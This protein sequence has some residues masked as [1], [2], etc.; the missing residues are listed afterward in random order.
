[1]DFTERVCDSFIAFVIAQAVTRQTQRGRRVELELDLVLL[2]SNL[3]ITA[4]RVSMLADDLIN[5]VLLEHLTERQRL[6]IRRQQRLI[7]SAHAFS[8]FLARWAAVRVQRGT[9]RRLTASSC[10]VFLGVR[11]AEQ[12][13]RKITE[14]IYVVSFVVACLTRGRREL[15]EDAG[16]VFFGDEFDHWIDICSLE[17]C[18]SKIIVE[19]EFLKG[20]R[21]PLLTALQEP[22]GRDGAVSV[23]EIGV[24]SVA[25]LRYAQAVVYASRSRAANVALGAFVTVHLRQISCGV[26]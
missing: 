15:I 25:N 21:D 3:C 20:G 17:D 5:L 1:M 6:I 12:T 11:E 18:N 16:F 10:D 22:H 7:T 9:R 19:R 26:L 8:T 24:R 23:Q 2:S 4:L 14:F 13:L